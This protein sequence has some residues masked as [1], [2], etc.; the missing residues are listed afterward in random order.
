MNRNRDGLIAAAIIGGA[1]AVIA[2]FKTAQAAA[3]CSSAFVSAL[4]GDRC[5]AAT[6][7]HTL[8][9]VGMIACAGLLV[10][11]AVTG[12]RRPPPAE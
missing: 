12:R 1:V 6:T 8:S 10:A 9:L 2:Y 5:S 4:A 11:A 7:V 3:V